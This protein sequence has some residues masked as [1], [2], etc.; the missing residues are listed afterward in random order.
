MTHGLQAPR[1]GLREGVGGAAFSFIVPTL[2][3]GN[4]FQRS[5]INDC[6][7]RIPT[8]ERG[9]ESNTP[10]RFALKALTGTPNTHHT[11]TPT[12]NAQGAHGSSRRGGSCRR[13]QRRNR[14]SRGSPHYPH[15]A[16]MSKNS[17][18]VWP[19]RPSRRSPD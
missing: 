9:N 6:S 12:T 16:T 4:V 10:K 17:Y 13:S 14:R 8:Q 11:N 2:L 7:K 15:T 5:G 18:W 1:Q 19:E 3:R